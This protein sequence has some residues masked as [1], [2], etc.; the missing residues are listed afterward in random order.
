[1]AGASRC[2]PRQQRASPQHARHATNTSAP[3][4][5]RVYSRGRRSH[6]SPMRKT[7]LALVILALAWIGY[8]AWPLYELA[9]LTRAIE[10]GDVAAVTRRVDFARV[11]T[12][13]TQQIV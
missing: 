1:M 4:C 6:S 12:S 5:R 9:Q 7:I 10:R 13:L 8:L 3:R 2:S 11:R